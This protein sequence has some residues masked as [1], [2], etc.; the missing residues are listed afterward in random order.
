MLSFLHWH[1]YLT[2]SFS[3][4]LLLFLSLTFSFHGIDS[5]SWSKLVQLFSPLYTLHDWPFPIVTLSSPCRVEIKR[6]RSGPSD[7]QGGESYFPILQRKNQHSVSMY[8]VLCTVD[9]SIRLCSARDVLYFNRCGVGE[10]EMEFSSNKNWTNKEMRWA[11]SVTP[12]YYINDRRESSF[13]F[14]SEPQIKQSDP[15]LWFGWGR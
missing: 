13:W 1:Y 8:T 14:P 10:S 4:T 6:R 3:S 5:S 15:I 7:S 12:A 2:W 11:R 9:C